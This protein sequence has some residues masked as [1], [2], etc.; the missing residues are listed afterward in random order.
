MSS[1]FGVRNLNCIEKLCY[2]NIKIFVNPKR[3]LLLV[4]MYRNLNP[5]IERH[6]FKDVMNVAF[7][8]VN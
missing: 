8:S 7:Y 3:F 5:G 1:I 6:F 2:G 4:R